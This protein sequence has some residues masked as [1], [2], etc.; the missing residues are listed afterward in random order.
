M[1]AVTGISHAYGI[2]DV[3]NPPNATVAYI[4]DV[5]QNGLPIEMK[6][7]STRMTVSE[8]LAFYKHRWSDTSDKKE[9]VPAY[10]EK[11]VGAWHILSKMEVQSSVVVQARKTDQGMTEGYISVTDTA[12]G[13]EPNRWTKEFP[14]MRGTQLLSNTE[15]VDK[16]RNAYTLILYN[17]YSISQNRDYYRAN[18]PS[19][20]WQYTR[21]GEKS[22]TAM[23]YFKKGIWYCEIAFTK[24]VDGKTVIFANLVEENE[25][26]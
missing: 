2:N 21:S 9:N 10:L 1:V 19:E 6:K 7:F 14:R 15:S 8:V 16:G 3:V 11:Q 13:G 26:G 20:G 17:E 4:G 5:V 22:S 12:Q 24:A 18:M 23:I 25:N